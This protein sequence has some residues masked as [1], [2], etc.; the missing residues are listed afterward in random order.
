MY[1]LCTIL[2]ICL[3]I[4]GIYYYYNYIVEPYRSSYKSIIFFSSKNCHHCIDFK[5][6]WDLF[7]NNFAHPDNCV[8]FVEVDVNKHPDIADRFSVHAYPTILG[9]KNG[10]KIMEFTGDRTYENLLKFYVH[11]RSV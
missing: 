5:P 4:F 7:V 10:K 8:E 9:V 3:I 1:I 2:L 6:L 11:F